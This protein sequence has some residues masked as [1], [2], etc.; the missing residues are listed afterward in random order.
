[1]FPGD[2]D[3]AP[4]HRSTDAG[5][6]APSLS[7]LPDLMGPPP[8]PPDPSSGPQPHLPE[9]QEFP[10]GAPSLLRYRNV[11]LRPSPSRGPERSPGPQ[12]PPPSG[13]DLTAPPQC[14]YLSGALVKLVW[15][16]R[17]LGVSEASWVLLPEG[18]WFWSGGAEE[19]GQVSQEGSGSV[20][21]H[22]W[23]VCL[24]EAGVESVGTAAE[25]RPAPIHT[26]PPGKGAPDLS[27]KLGGFIPAAAIVGAPLILAAGAWPCHEVPRRGTGP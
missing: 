3:D 18:A 20:A 9:T 21:V 14:R 22:V 27:G 25:P 17:G 2:T 4:S 1:M 6:P 24:Q 7:H 15:S 5:I 12:P 23:G 26:P 10:L 11:G 8:C 19:T 16:L 13:S